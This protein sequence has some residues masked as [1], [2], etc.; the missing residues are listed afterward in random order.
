MFLGNNSSFAAKVREAAVQSLFILTVKHICL[1][2]ANT[3]H[4]FDDSFVRDQRGDFLK[5]LV[6]HIFEAS[7]IVPKP[8]RVLWL[9]PSFLSYLN[10]LKIHNASRSS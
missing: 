9:R 10:Y 5:I 2:P 1:A 3:Q 7:L 4:H 6:L 8:V